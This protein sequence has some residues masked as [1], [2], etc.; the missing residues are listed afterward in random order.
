MPKEPVHIR[1]ADWVGPQDFWR[2]RFE[3]ADHGTG[4]TVL[5]YSTEER[6]KGPVWH[7]HPYDEVF[8]L[9]QGRALFTI[10]ETRIEAVGG[11]ILIGPA[12]VPHKFVNLDDA[13]LETTD[14]HLSDRWIQTNL[15]DPELDA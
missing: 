8:I 13:R 9:R 14:I 6:G 5:F 4:V 10:G 12:H 2:G 1:H 7:V 11:D 15:P 3:G